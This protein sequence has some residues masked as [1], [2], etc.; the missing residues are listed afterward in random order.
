MSLLEWAGYASS[1]TSA[2]VRRMDRAQCP[3]FK[4]EFSNLDLVR[5]ARQE[6]PPE[7]VTQSALPVPSLSP[8]DPKPPLP[9][10]GLQHLSE[11][12][13]QVKAGH[14]DF[15]IDLLSRMID[16]SLFAET[17]RMKARGLRANCYLQRLAKGGPGKCRQ[18][19]SKPWHD[20]GCDRRQK[21]RSSHGW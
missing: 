11:I 13:Y 3:L 12:E 5:V 16:S 18:R 8:S 14:T 4:G 19:Q 1:E 17:V 20:Y 21:R 7:K 6:P 2:H 15:A 10:Y 9:D